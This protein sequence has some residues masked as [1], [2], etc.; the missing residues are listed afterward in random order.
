MEPDG[1]FFCDLS[2]TDDPESF[3]LDMLRIALHAEDFKG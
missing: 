2:L 3:N 1:P